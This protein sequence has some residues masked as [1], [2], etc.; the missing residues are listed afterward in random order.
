MSAFTKYLLVL[1]AGFA[2]VS[3]AGEYDW[4]VKQNWSPTLEKK[5]S[6]FVHTMGES[7]CRSLNACLTGAASNPFYAARTPKTRQF[8]SDC[9]D[10]PFSL[11]MYFAWMEELPFDYVNQVAQ[12][13]PVNEPNSDIRYSKFGNKPAGYR[14]IQAGQT[15]DAYREL[16]NMRDSV[17]TA[18]YRMHYSEISDFYPT[19]LDL[20]NIA[21][22]TVA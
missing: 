2:Q 1:L 22:G 17:S 8:L 14:V 11:R 15:Y 9:A 21:P 19:L 6:E 13:D 12:A 18:T 4:Q 16:T 5:F 20:K 10:L 3:W 7:N